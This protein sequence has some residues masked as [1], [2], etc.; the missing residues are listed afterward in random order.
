MED[1][2]IIITPTEPFTNIINN[3]DFIKIKDFLN[4][5]KTFGYNQ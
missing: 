3:S 5:N 2:P 4:K 1:N